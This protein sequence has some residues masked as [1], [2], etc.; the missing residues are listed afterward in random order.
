[1]SPSS[2]LAIS[3]AAIVVVALAV[4]IPICV[5]FIGIPRRYRKQIKQLENKYYY[6]DGLFRGQDSQYVHRLESISRTNLL[7]VDLYNDFSS[8]YQHILDFDDHYADEEIKQLTA[9][10]NNKQY[11]SL[12][13]AME[14]AKKALG[15]F[16]KSVNE[17][18]SSLLDVIRPEEESR[19]EILKLKESYREVKQL[20]FNSQND[21]ESV[22]TSF[23]TVFD[24]LDKLFKEFDDHID[25]AEYEEA[26]ALLPT[27]DK[28]ISS[29]NYVL[30]DMPNLCILVDQMIPAQIKEVSD[31]HAELEKKDI[32]LYHL[33]FKSYSH[34]WGVALNSIKKR[35]RDLDISGV[36]SDCNRIQK[37]I[38][39]MREGLLKESDDKD[40]FT[41]KNAKIYKNVSDLDKKFIDIVALLPEAQQVYKIDEAHLQ[42][43][44][45]LKQLINKV[46]SEK[47]N[48]DTIIRTSATQPFSSLYDK[49][50][51]LETDYNSTAERVDNFN[52]YLESLKSSSEDAY[53]LMFD[54]YNKTKECEYYMRSLALDDFFS[55]YNAAIQQ[56]YDYIN[57]INDILVVTPIDVYAVN[58]RV[59][60]LKALADPLF[61]DIDTKYKEAQLAETSVVFVNRDRNQQNDVHKELLTLEKQF[62][63]GNFESVHES[64]SSIYRSKHIE[65]SSNGDK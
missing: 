49:L 42:E 60:S 39:A 50:T 7:Y 15:I 10:L 30:K 14:E 27:I 22:S 24:N 63:T 16:E 64:A 31:L 55:Q 41:E 40:F 61:I 59:S 19:K 5:R 17:F 36:A 11:K 23:M 52:L 3:I 20:Y 33:G 8:K 21:L 44:E 2:I 43:V 56:I 26:N 34:D 4:L 9:L 37:E 53:N 6:L 58:E 45:E 54:Y 12:K 65:G 28:V 38:E 1:M 25:S 32:P 13:P 62:Y 18:D 51:E 35:L 46:T 48:L 29:L 57:Q 47:R